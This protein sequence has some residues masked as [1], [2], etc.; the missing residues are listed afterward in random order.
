MNYNKKNAER[1]DASEEEDEREVQKDRTDD[2]N[3][4]FSLFFPILR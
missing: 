1:E 3:F 4:P 2:D